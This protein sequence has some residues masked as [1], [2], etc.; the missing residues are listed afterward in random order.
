MYKTIGRMKY[1][2]LANNQQHASGHQSKG[3]QREALFSFLNAT[4]AKSLKYQRFNNFEVF[5]QIA[6]NTQCHRPKF[7]FTNE[8]LID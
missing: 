4:H 2:Q 6:T 7:T 5:K 3:G 1:T 8:L